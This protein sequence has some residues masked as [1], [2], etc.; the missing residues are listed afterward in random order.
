[1]LD[2][3]FHRAIFLEQSP[4]SVPC[5]YKVCSVPTKYARSQKS[6]PGPHKVCLVLTMQ[7]WHVLLRAHKAKSLLSSLTGH[8]YCL[9][10][11]WDSVKEDWYWRGKP[12][13]LF[14]AQRLNFYLLPSE[15]F[16]QSSVKNFYAVG[17]VLVCFSTLIRILC[18][19]LCLSFCWIKW[20]SYGANGKIR[21]HCQRWRWR[22][23][24]GFVPKRRCIATGDHD[25]DDFG[26]MVESKKANR[27]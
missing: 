3:K 20:R 5:P 23:W 19:G 16:L 27:Q 24:W 10:S 11:Q 4:Q 8:A 6:V 13:Y 12:F 26:V 1:M 14:W 9:N 22:W 2:C 21:L 25:G 18:S 7:G 15:K 17:K